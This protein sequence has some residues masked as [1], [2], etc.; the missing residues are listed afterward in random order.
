MRK[1][2]NLETKNQLASN[3]KVVQLLRKVIKVIP[4]PQN[5]TD[6]NLSTTISSEITKHRTSATTVFMKVSSVYMTENPS[7]SFGAKGK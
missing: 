2:K 4:M 5:V 7:R 3:L 1:T 6:I